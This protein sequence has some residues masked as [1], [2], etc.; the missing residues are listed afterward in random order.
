M[1]VLDEPVGPL[2]VEEG[3]VVPDGEALPS[4]RPVV[5]AGRAAM[6]NPSNES[7]PPIDLLTSV[8][9]IPVGD[10]MIWRPYE[11]LR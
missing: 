4:A 9:R 2:L 1:S 11:A 10:G 7:T 8:I 5:H 6:P 3:G